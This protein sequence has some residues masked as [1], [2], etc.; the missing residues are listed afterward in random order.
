MD[1]KCYFQVFPT[2]RF[3]ASGAVKINSTKDLAWF[4]HGIWKLRFD[5]EY[6][7]TLQTQPHLK[8]WHIEQFIKRIP[9][10]TCYYNQVVQNYLYDEIE[11]R[12]FGVEIRER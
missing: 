1:L 7:T 8:E 3:Y 2:E 5:G 11:N 10:V 6:R 12:I 9:N 4:H